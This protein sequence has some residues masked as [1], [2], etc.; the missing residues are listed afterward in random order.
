[1]KLLQSESSWLETWLLPFYHKK[2]RYVFVY[3]NIGG[4]SSLIFELYNRTSLHDVCVCLCMLDIKALWRVATCSQ[5]SSPFIVTWRVGLLSFCL[6][7]CMSG[8]LRVSGCC[9]G[10]T[11]SDNTAILCFHLWHFIIEAASKRFKILNGWQ[12]CSCQ[13]TVNSIVSAFSRDLL[14]V[15]YNTWCTGT[16]RNLHTPPEALLSF[17]SE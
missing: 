5:Q 17:F 16:S 2:T 8:S 10:D 3:I 14:F 6:R 13:Y 1:M 11:D 12:R 4:W 9:H 7:L 15:A